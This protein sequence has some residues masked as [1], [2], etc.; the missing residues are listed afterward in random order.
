MPA[1][2]DWRDLD[3]RSEIRPGPSPVRRSTHEAAASSCSEA[4]GLS[5]RRAATRWGEFGSNLPALTKY[6]PRHRSSI[7]SE[8]SL[9]VWADNVPAFLQEVHRRLPSLETRMLDFA[10]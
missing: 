7:S 6:R 5:L 8:I 3:Q 10:N 1:A 4:A 2:S 9:L